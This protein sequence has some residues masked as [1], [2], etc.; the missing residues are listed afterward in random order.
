MP[1]IR[2]VWQLKGQAA[3]SCLLEGERQDFGNIF[4]ALAAL[5]GD[6]IA[7]GSNSGAIHF[8]EAHENVLQRSSIVHGCTWVS[9]DPC[10]LAEANACQ[11]L[12]KCSRY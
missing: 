1:F 2:Q 7:A 6:R 9:Q 10:M 8:Y 12:T 5:P 3:P 11:P 4:H